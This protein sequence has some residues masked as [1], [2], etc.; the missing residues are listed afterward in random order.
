MDEMSE[1]EVRRRKA[2]FRAQRRGFREV[3]MIFIAFADA[4]LASLDADE[5]TQ[6][7]ALLDVPDW[8][9]YGWFMGHEPAPPEFDHS[10]FKRLCAYRDNLRAKA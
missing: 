3:D 9:I 5:L 10:V 8:A 4:H 1:I 6:F 2:R 7:E